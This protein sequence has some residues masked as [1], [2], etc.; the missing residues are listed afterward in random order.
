MNEK[1][2]KVLNIFDEKVGLK[3][4]INQEKQLKIKELL[5]KNKQL[6]GSKNDNK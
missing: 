2:Q 1:K 6:E 5:L 4:P 3:N